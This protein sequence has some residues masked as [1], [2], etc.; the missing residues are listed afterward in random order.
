MDRAEIYFG[1]P[2]KLGMSPISQQQMYV[3][4]LEHV[5]GNPWFAPEEYVGHLDALMAPFG[6]NVPVVRAA[7]GADSQIVYRPLE[8]LLLP[9]PWYTGRVVLIGDA[10]HATT[11]HMASGAGL[12][13]E[14]GLVLAEELTKSADA[15]VALRSFMGRRFERARVVVETSVRVGELEMA[16]GDRALQTTALTSAT[17]ALAQPY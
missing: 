11:P 7:L 5:P 15:A 17:Q 12:A 4:A 10:A 3:F 13:V 6:G 16:G 9:D 8:W 14:D 1:G 2:T